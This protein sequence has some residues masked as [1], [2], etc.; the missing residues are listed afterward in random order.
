MKIKLFLFILAASFVLL[1]ARC[2][3]PT[4]NTNTNINNNT[5]TNTN[6]II[7]I[8]IQNLA[9][10]PETVNIKKGD[11]V[12]WKN[13]D[14]ADHVVASNPHPIHT[15]LPGLSSPIIKTGGTYEFTFD[16][17]GEFGYH[18]HLHPSMKGKI[19]VE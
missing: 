5:N 7:T 14:S 2:T 18:C 17:V 10:S 6:R 13:L 1:G 11:T 4:S 9:F 19:I 8:N 12:I 3:I 16:K 15:D